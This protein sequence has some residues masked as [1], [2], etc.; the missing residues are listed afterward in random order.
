[1]DMKRNV[2]GIVEADVSTTAKAR[3]AK[4]K[5]YM[6]YIKTHIENVQKAYDGMCKNPKLQASEPIR[7]A[8]EELKLNIASH[9]ASK[10]SDSEFE[11]YRKNFHSINDEEKAENEEDFERAWEHHYTVNSHHPEYWKHDNVILDMSLPAILEM[12]CDWQSFKYIGQGPAIEYWAKKKEEKSKIMTSK[13][14]EIV[15]KLLSIL[16]D[17]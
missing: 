1:M 8:L 6:D 14:V 11:P 16:G 3:L 4:E 13:T 2:F 5:E 15:D 12:L 7:K 10:Y 9:D 17:W